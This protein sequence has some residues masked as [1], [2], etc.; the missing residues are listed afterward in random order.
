[1]K[2]GS[3]RSYGCCCKETLHLME[4]CRVRLSVLR[5][6]HQV[7]TLYKI[8]KVYSRMFGTNCFHVKAKNERFTAAGSRCRQNPKCEIFMSSFGRLR[9]KIAPKNVQH[10]CFSPFNQSNHWLVALALLL[11]SSLLKLPNIL[12]YYI[13]SL[14][15]ALW[16]I[17]RA[18]MK[19]LAEMYF[20]PLKQT[21][22]KWE[23]NNRTI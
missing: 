3:L 1:M 19:N 16:R 5:L 11:P 7:G 22:K 15:R 21:N 14:C 17:L 9:Q 10:D 4:F 18:K 13:L 6:F 8:G 2:L 20:S 23:S 12:Y